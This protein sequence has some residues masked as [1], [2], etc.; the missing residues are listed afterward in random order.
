MNPNFADYK[1]L[2]AFDMPQLETIL[3]ETYESTGPYGAKSVGEVPI[4]GPAPAIVNAVYDA[5]GVKIFDLPLTAEKVLA[6]LKKR[7]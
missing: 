6:A 5:V 2:N 4:N 3:V 1:L 7:E